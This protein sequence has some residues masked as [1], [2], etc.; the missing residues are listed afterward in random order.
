MDSTV[1]QF[2]ETSFAK[3]AYLYFPHPKPA[4]VFI[5]GN[6]TC[7][8]IF[9]KQYLP[10]SS[11][12]HILVFDLPGHGSSSNSKIASEK[13][14][15][16]SNYARCLKELLDFLQISNILIVGSSLGG[17]IGLDFISLFSEMVN[18]ILIAG[19][20]PIRPDIDSINA[21][22][23]LGHPA[24]KLTSKLEQ[25]TEQESILYHTSAG[26]PQTFTKVI[27][28]GIR[29]DG[30]ARMNMIKALSTGQGEDELEL[31]QKSLIPLAIANGVK[32]PFVN[33]DYINNQV[34]YKNLYENKKFDCSHVPFW[35]QA[36]EFNTFLEKFY[37]D[38][39]E[40]INK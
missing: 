3:I 32:D 18:G 14:Y 2:Y 20:P 22:F 27:D 5:H 10:L 39:C 17:H 21:G 6:S 1:E 8:E 4:I 40:K 23:I 36:D 24:G 15:T 31:V 16:V 13:C 33:H 37:N 38:V 7:K 12:L 30:S 9:E 19:T 34:K 35:E 25:F 29:T 26:F 11:K 28:A